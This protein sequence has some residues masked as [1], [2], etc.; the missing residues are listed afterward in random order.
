MQGSRCPSSSPVFSRSLGAGPWRP[1]TRRFGRSLGAGPLGFRARLGQACLAARSGS[2]PSF[3][4]PGQRRSRKSRMM[5]R[6]TFKPFRAQQG[7]LQLDIAAVA[8]QP[9]RGRHDAVT[10]DVPA[11]TVAHDVAHGARGPGTASRRRHV[12]VRGHAPDGNAA[13]D[14][15]DTGGEVGHRSLFYVLGSRLFVPCPFLVLRSWSFVPRGFSE[16]TKTSARNEDRNEERNEERRTTNPTNQEP[17]TENGHVQNPI[18]NP[19]PA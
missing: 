14:G 5:V 6:V 4:T 12:A 18:R 11:R 9:S 7:A 15:Q 13:D 2:P 16:S 10:G 19:P 8:A 1:S 17:R 3:A